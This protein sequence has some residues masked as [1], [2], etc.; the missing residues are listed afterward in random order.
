M[1]KEYA[2]ISGIYWAPRSVRAGGKKKYLQ[3]RQRTGKS[4]YLPH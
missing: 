3:G 1:L 4:F 2:F